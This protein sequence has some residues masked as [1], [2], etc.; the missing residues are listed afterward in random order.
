MIGKGVEMRGSSAYVLGMRALMP[1]LLLLAFLVGAGTTAS[2]QAE[3][4]RYSIMK[5]EPWLA[6]KYRSPRGTVQHAVIPKPVERT[7]PSHR[8]EPPPPIVVPSTGRVLPN[9]PIAPSQP[10]TVGG[11]AESFS[12][13]AVRCSHQAAA[14]GA[15]AT[16]NPSAYIGTCINQ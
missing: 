11:R 4:D 3:D 15:A 8:F 5:P 16:G 9:L 6:P 12:D 2:A 1:V 10:A 14:Y 7:T 13:R